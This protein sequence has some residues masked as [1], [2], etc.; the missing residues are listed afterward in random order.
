M[1]LAR[2]AGRVPELYFFATFPNDSLFGYQWG[3]DNSGQAGGSADADIDAPEAWDYEKGNTSVK[4]G[5]I[6]S[7]V[8]GNHDDLSGKVSGEGTFTD[9]HGTHVAGIAGAKTNNEEGVAGVSW[10][11]PIHSEDISSF[12]PS[13]IYTDI[14]NAVDAGCFVLNN[15]WGGPS[16]SI[17]IRLALAYAYKMNRVSVAAMGNTGNSVPQFPADC[18]QG[19]LAVGSIKNTGILSGF[20]SKG[21]HIDVVAPGGKN[22]WPYTNEEDIL[23]TWTSGSNSYEFLAGTS[24][25]APF[26]TG[27]A[28]L[29]KSYKPELDNDDVIEIIKLSGTDRYGKLKEGWDSELGH[30]L[31][32]ARNALDFLT[33]P[34][35][36]SHESS[37]GGSDVGMSSSLMVFISVPGLA[38]G[39]YACRRYTV[40][41]NVTF[42]DL[43]ACPPHAWGRGVW[44]TGYS[45]ENP[46]CGLG[47]SAPVSGSINKTGCSMRTYVYEV[48]NVTGEYIGWIPCQPSQVCYAYTALGI[49]DYGPPEA[50]ITYPNG[51]EYFRSGNTVHITWQVDDEYVEGVRCGLSY[52]L[53]G[54]GG[55]WIGIASASN[56]EVDEDG[57]GSYD[58]KIPAGQPRVESCCRVRVIANDSNQH[59]GIDMSDADFTIEYL[60]KS[61]EWPVPN[62]G[63]GIETP[64]YTYIDAPYPN[65]FNPLTAIRFGLVERSEVTLAIYDV[66][67]RVVKTILQSAPCSPGHYL[68]YWNGLNDGGVRVS[69]GIYFLRFQADGYAKTQKLVLIK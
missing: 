61:D 38:D 55:F 65:P 30:G 56:L 43:Y 51:G 9:P 42:A 58:W 11:S 47:W 64:D 4:I 12:D 33:Y 39:T 44:T 50:A 49:K 66:N 29:L 2:E 21:N 15:S 18:G 31:I 59:Q 3:L 69:A 16:Y 54:E 28:A 67:G 26:A 52:S 63:G 32:N 60:T 36:L 22:L 46:N 24:M 27:V 45:M 19:I 53:D 13:E 68:Q 62:Q 35:R 48:W 34:F 10:Y 57:E 41:R 8:K 25:A 20:S 5:I 14:H 1:E 6:D 7:G 17:T 40:E 23:S 37:T